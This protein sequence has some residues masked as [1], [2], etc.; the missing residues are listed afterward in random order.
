MIN[1]NR[2]SVADAKARLVLLED[3]RHRILGEWWVKHR[4]IQSDIKMLESYIEQ[5]T[6]VVLYD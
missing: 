2:L 3:E 5:K 4:V 1:T 6:R